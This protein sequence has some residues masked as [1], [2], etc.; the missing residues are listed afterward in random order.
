VLEF[1]LH[2]LSN[3][4][5]SKLHSQY[6][7]APHSR[8]LKISDREPIRIHPIDAASR[9]IEHGMIVRVFN[10]RG[11]C[12][13]GVV[14]SDAVIPG[15]VQMATGAWLDLAFGDGDGPP[16]DKH[17]NANVL[18]RDVGTSEIAQG[19]TAN[20]CLVQIE[21]YVGV[22]PMTTCFEPPEIIK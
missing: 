13:A 19:S 5:A 8:K 2:L 18:T 12:L 16:L 7:H 21:R 6:D 9:N 3:Q 22:L 14:L 10:A 1:P 4:P 11:S 17:G 20:S 15:V